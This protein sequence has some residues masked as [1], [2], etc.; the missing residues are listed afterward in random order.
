VN[1]PMPVRAICL[2]S[3][4]VKHRRRRGVL[5]LAIALCLPGCNKYPNFQSREL[6]P[7]DPDYPMVN[8]HPGQVVQFTA[9]VPPTLPNELRIFYSVDFITRNNPDG[10]LLA[11]E[12]P[13]PK[14]RWKPTDEFYVE[15]PIQLKKEG[16]TYRGSIALDYFQPGSCGWHFSQ[17]RSPIVRNPVISYGNIFHGRPVDLAK[18]TP[19]LRDP[20]AGLGAKSLGTPILE[21]HGDG[22]NERIDI[23]C[24]QQSKNPP[25]KDPNVRNQPDQ[26]NNCADL[27]FAN[28]FFI[29]LPA[30]L[31]A[32]VP[33]NELM[34]GPPLFLDRTHAQSIILE[35]HDID[36]LVADYRTH[37]SVI[38]PQ[39]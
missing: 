29:D 14:C 9:I 6:K 15:L 18:I 7:G 3:R 17:M 39:K 30:D 27:R 26:I 1:R 32:S 24:T 34:D 22:I 11:Y 20:S 13:S 16:N 37:G 23:W 31:Y 5:V 21:S 33:R 28:G 8:D 35:F 36:E 10:T 25:N 4:A 38:G 12:S 19:I 2:M